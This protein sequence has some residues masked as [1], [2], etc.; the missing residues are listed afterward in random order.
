MLE[1][2]LDKNKLPS[3]WNT[4]LNH[5][6]PKTGS[7]SPDGKRITLTDDFDIKNSTKF[8]PK[9]VASKNSFL[10]NSVADSKMKTSSEI[11]KVE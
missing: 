10:S 4:H 7:L 9:M 2:K 3:D 8:I 1:E 11:K 6:N 5:L